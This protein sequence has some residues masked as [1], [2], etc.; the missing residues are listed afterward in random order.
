MMA[1]YAAVGR[2]SLAVLIGG[3]MG[4]VYAV[5]NLYMLGRGVQKAVN[6]GDEQMARAGLRASYSLRMVCMLVVAVLAFAFPFAE[7]VP[8]LIALL[9]PRI[10]IF[11]LQ[12]AAKRTGA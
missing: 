2:F 1:V 5:L 3:L 9:F 10:T 4:S 7:G 6:C 8:C 11:V 12:L